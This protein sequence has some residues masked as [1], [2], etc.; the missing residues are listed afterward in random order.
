MPQNVPARLLNARGTY[1]K[2]PVKR[3]KEEIEIGSILYGDGT[4]ASGIVTGKTPIGVVFDAANRLAVALTDVKKDGTA[5]SERMHWSSSYCDTP[6]LQNCTTT[7]I[8][9]GT[10]LTPITCGVDGR[11]NTNA[12]L[13]SSCNGTTYAA[14]ATNNY[15]PTGCAK[16][17]LQKNEMVFTQHERFAEYLF[18][19]TQIDASLTLLKGYSAT[20]V[21]NDYYWSSTENG[22]IHAWL[23]G[24]LN[25]TRY[26][27]YKNGTSNSVRPV[28][29][30]E[31]LFLVLP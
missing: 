16:R 10:N 14:T 21:K 13:A 25:G 31:V 3:K 8:P 29:A 20:T 9:Y 11:L 27:S 22:N 26:Y 19:K 1:P 23:F 7:E 17:F 15:Q 6:G 18:T 5:G 12:I 30:F 24:M 2:Q 4:V 28:L